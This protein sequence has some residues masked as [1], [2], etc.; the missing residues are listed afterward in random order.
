MSQIFDAIQ[1]SERE[2]SG[3]DSPA[4]S[5]AR[6]VLV[7]AERR[8]TE[9]WNSGA[10]ADMPESPDG[11][12][13]APATVAEQVAEAAPQVDPLAEEAPLPRPVIENE[14]AS[15]FRTVHTSV[16]AQS[17]L[18]SLTDGDS[19]AAEAF[20]S[21]GVRLRDIRSKRT[22]RTLLIA[23]AIPQEGKSIVA[24]NLASTLALGSQHKV[25]LLEGDLR[26]PGLTQTFG[27]GNAVGLSEW[28]RGECNI[29]Q[30]IYRIE[31]SGL[32]FMPA[33]S[34]V[35]NPLELLQSGRLTTL[36]RRLSG[37]F[38]WIVI[39]SPPVV[40]LADAAVWAQS[41]DGI[42]LVTR[43]GVTEKRKLARALE[44]IDIKKVIGGLVNC[45]SNLPQDYDYYFNR[46]GNSVRNGSAAV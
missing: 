33:G 28:L 16:M 15:E 25:L 8:A 6:D 29:T 30:S 13:S 24:A 3:A 22:L 41:A 43:Q 27:L 23:S 44:A 14:T 46:S 18:V 40:P 42:L 9:N 39:D 45:S 35:R 2:S 10:P 4:L 5:E 1:R 11:L 32:C 34:G 21:L 38:D 7:R 20:R 26:Q 36:M 19:L 31:E 12:F 37:W 17:R